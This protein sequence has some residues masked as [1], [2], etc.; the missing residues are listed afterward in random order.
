MSGK[1]SLLS[2]PS[3]PAHLDTSLAWRNLSYVTRS[4][5]LP[6]GVRVMWSRKEPW[7]GTGETPTILR[8]EGTG[9]SEP[10]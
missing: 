8:A 6:L 5:N 3:G 2:K 7:L 1:G 10:A 4:C 9:V